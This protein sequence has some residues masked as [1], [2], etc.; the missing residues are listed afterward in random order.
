M[1]EESKPLKEPSIGRF[2]GIVM[3]GQ[4]VLEE[5]R[6]TED[7]SGEGP[8]LQKQGLA[9]CWLPVAAVAASDREYPTRPPRPARRIAALRSNR[10]GV[11]PLH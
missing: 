10:E 4:L 8:L 9:A 11:S 7:A 6:L 3:I 2:N 5:S 1:T